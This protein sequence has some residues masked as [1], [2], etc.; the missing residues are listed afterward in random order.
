MIKLIHGDFVQVAATTLQNT[1]IDLIVADPPDNIGLKYDGFADNEPGWVYEDKIYD[2]LDTMT[3]LTKGPI[4]FTFNEKWTSSVEAAIFDLG[5][6]IVQRL[7]WH[8]TFGQDQ[9]RNGK[10]AL[11][12]RP[13][14]WLNSPHINADLI[15]V[16]SARQLKY[17]DKRASPGGKLPQNVW[18]FSRICGSFK[19][20]RSWVPTQLPEQMVERIV[21]GHCI[22]GG[23]VLDPFLGTGTTAIICQKMGIK[24]IGIEI[25]EPTIQKT[26]QHLGVQYES[27]GD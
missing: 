26:S 18:E 6:D 19:E 25:S 8:Y 10:Y 5:I 1:Q 24:C 7:Q 20:R 23:C 22:S 2:W 15:K 3:N 9:T 21:L 12:Y 17:K 16:P 13:V 27:Q 14:Y 4:F 11:C